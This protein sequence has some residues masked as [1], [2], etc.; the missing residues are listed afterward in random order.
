MLRTGPIAIAKAGLIAIAKAAPPLGVAFKR[1]VEMQYWRRQKSTQGT[2]RNSHYEFFYTEFFGLSP[3]DY[4]GR[5]VLDVGCGPRG[6]LEWCDAAAE[7]VGLDP[8]VPS[9]RALGIDQ[10]RMSYVAAP[11]ETI[12][13]PDGHF[14]IVASF[15]SLDHVENV[16]RAISEVERV[17]KPGGRFLLIVEVDHPATLAEPHT[18]G[19]GWLRQRLGE[20]FEII[21]FTE[22]GQGQGHAVYRALRESWPV[23][24]GQPAFVAMSMTK[25]V[26]A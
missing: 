5:R 18:I 1:F 2:L 26:R 3:A 6:S 15:N 9:Y 4:E 24:D 14:D 22:A 13:F 25:A 10:H 20:S 16:E 8:L 19:E 7:R 12:P 17:L 11:V 21:S 23:M